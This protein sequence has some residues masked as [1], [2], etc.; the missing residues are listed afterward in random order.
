MA[1]RFKNNQKISYLAL[2]K[3]KYNSVRLF[4]IRHIYV[5]EKTLGGIDTHTHFQLPFV[6]WALQKKSFF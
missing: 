6:S 1:H 5:N 2:F 3:F 4:T